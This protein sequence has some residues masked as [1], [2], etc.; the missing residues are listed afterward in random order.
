MNNNELNL[1]IGY[2]LIL[3]GMIKANIFIDLMDGNHLL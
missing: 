3:N 2:E 1:L